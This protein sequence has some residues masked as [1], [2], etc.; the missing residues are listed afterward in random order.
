MNLNRMGL[1]RYEG[2]KIMTFSF[3]DELSLSEKCNMPHRLPLYLY[4]CKLRD[5]SKLLSVLIDSICGIL[6]IRRKLDS[7]KPERFT[8][9]VATYID[10]CLC[11]PCFALSAAW[12]MC[13]C[14]HLFCMWC[15]CLPHPF[16]QHVSLRRANGKATRRHLKFTS[17][18]GEVDQ[19]TVS[20][21]VCDRGYVY[22]VCSFSK[23]WLL[24]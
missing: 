15:H 2:E 1:E 3:T 4:Y 12:L 16:S 11:M 20:V 5:K 8:T 21:F 6:S 19:S 14:L 10:P 22:T 7:V 13:L 18:E 24:E 17:Q 23:Y 9:R